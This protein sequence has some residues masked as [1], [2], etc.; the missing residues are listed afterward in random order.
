ML[1]VVVTGGIG[2]GKSTATEYF[3]SKG[4]LSLGLD[5]AAHA[6]LEPGGSTFDAI[7]GAFGSEILDDEGRVDRARLA[8]RAF[9]D[10]GACSELNRIM[11]PAV[12][13]RINSRL[14]DLR[15]RPDA[16]SVVVL[17]VPL[18]VEAP[19]FASV[20]D[21][22]VAI[23]AD[24]DVRVARCVAVGRSEQDAR[25]RLACQA[26][27]E[28]REALADRVIV[29]EGTQEEFRAELDRFWDE[30]VELRAAQ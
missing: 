10:R 22:V 12:A 17:E 24:A 16:P 23:S 7:V 18:L 15:G 6:L 27:D 8:T 30:V 14:D 4:A 19:A 3:R 28:E 2:S 11:H 21:A 5:E 20:A 13:E 26:T 25:A 9:A 29:N 1:V